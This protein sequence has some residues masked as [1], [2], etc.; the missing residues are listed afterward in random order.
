MLEEVIGGPLEET[1]QGSL[2]SGQQLAYQ[3]LARRK[4]EKIRGTYLDA[5]QE[6]VD[7]QNFVHPRMNQ[8][9]ARTG[10]MSMERPALQTLP[11]GRVIRDCFIPRTGNVL[12]S[13]DFDQIEMRL[14]AHFAGDQGLIDAIN[15]GDIHTATAQQVYQDSTIGH[16]DPRRQIAKSV[17]FAKIYG[18]GPEKIALTAGVSLAEAKEFLDQYDKNFPG[19][20]GFQ[21]QVAKIAEARKRDEGR[22]YVKTPIGRLEV[23]KD[24]RDYALVN[25]LIQGMA[26]DV[27]KEA[28][29]RLD[30]AGC[31]DF[32]LLPVHD[33]VIFDVPEDDVDEV[34]QLITRAMRDDRWAVP[35]TVGIDGPL[36]RWGDKYA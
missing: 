19:V 22:A 35:I 14:L 34:K 20:R 28:L 15:S 6:H 8:L 10:R 4:A 12:L 25:A 29:V 18:A 2:N 33:E 24:D 23:S 1:V 5:F 7:G 17:G 16:K 36:S 21:T 32:M 3:V 9:G 27:F 11:R 30:E 13:A 31:G 26:A